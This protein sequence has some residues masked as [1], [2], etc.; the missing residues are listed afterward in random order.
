MNT[1][2]VIGIAV[3]IIAVV[4]AIQTIQQSHVE[5]QQSTARAQSQTVEYAVLD[6]VNEDQVTFTTGGLVTVRTE[7]I[8]NTYRRLGGQG[9]GSFVDLLNQIGSLGWNLVEKDGE[10]WIFSR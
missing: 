9:R 5:A 3:L 8:R 7:S 4:V 2:N 1:K 10:V 6:F